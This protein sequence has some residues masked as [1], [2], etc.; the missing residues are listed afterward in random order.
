MI[1]ASVTARLLAEFKR[2]RFHMDHH[3]FVVPQQCYLYVEVKRK[4]WG[5][6][7]T[8]PPIDRGS[9]TPIPRGRLKFLG[10]T[11]KWEL[12][13]YRFS[14]EYWDHREVEIGAP[15]DLMLSMIVE[16]LCGA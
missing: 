15:E 16:K 5:S 13:P 12:Q 14:D 4:K 1:V 10:T 8:R 6:R 7:E 9:T 3:V 11:E 2:R